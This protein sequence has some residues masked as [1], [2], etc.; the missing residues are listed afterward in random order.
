MSTILLS[1]KPEYVRII[2]TGE[3]KYEFRK[4]RCRENVDKIVFYASSPLK[5]V[6]GEAYIEDI[7]EDTPHEVWNQAK[8]AS[9]ITSN[10]FFSYYEGKEVAIAYKLM[11]VKAYS[12]PKELTDYGIDYAPQS[13]V[14]ID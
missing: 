5:Q 8:T 4:K 3:K 13:Y 12:E 14:Y 7:L 6:V 11:N 1:I 2:F 10:Y 9:G